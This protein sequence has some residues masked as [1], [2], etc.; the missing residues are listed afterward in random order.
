MQVVGGWNVA[1]SDG[2]TRQKQTALFVQRTE[3]ISTVKNS[4]C[5]FE[6]IK[7]NRERPSKREED[8]GWE[9]INK[10]LSYTSVIYLFSWTMLVYCWREKV[11]VKVE[12]GRK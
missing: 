1:H 4:G 6:F 9:R 12:T 7:M 2:S 11:A 5:L 3:S 10:D 8:W